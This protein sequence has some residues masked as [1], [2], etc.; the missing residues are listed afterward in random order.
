LEV[1]WLAPTRTASRTVGE[2]RFAVTRMDRNVAGPA[3]FSVP[4]TL[5]PKS[6]RIHT[7]RDYVAM[8][9]EPDC[10]RL[11]KPCAWCR[12]LRRILDLLQTLGLDQNTVACFSSDNGPHRE[13]GAN[14]EFFDSNGPLRGNKRDLTEG[15]IRVPFIVRWPDK[16]EAGTTCDDVGY[17]ADFLPTAAE[18][19]QV[20][21]P[22]NIDGLPIDA[23][24]GRV[25]ARSRERS[26]YW[27]FYE[28][29]SAQ[30]V[31]YGNWKGIASP[32]GSDQ[33]EVYNLA[34][35]PGEQ[36][37]LAAGRPDVVE[38][39]KIFIRTSHTDSPHWTATRRKNRRNSLPLRSRRT[40][41]TASSSAAN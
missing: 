38:Q 9:R 19:A 7:D 5:G 28:Q 41:V 16:I 40:R 10:E 34:D 32:M 37:N 6:C 27:E 20:T 24:F 2:M 15:G 33:I 11:V 31:R 12:R 8:A 1:K 25:N 35:H 17:F 21:A 23:V 18:I 22:K 3:I 26:L 14:P 13:G 39:I 36:T 30:A 29:G 4:P